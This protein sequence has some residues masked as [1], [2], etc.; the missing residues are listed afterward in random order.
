MK[1]SSYMRKEQFYIWVYN[2]Y[3][4]ERAL[5]YGFVVVETLTK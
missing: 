4:I 3:C 1:E 5:N 2:F